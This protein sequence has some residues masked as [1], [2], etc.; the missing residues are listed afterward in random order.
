MVGGDVLGR[1]EDA[2]SPGRGRRRWPPR[3]PC[4]LTSANRSRTLSAVPVNCFTSFL[5]PGR[6]SSGRVMLPAATLSPDDGLSSRGRGDARR[7]ARRSPC[8]ARVTVTAPG[9]TPAASSS[10]RAQR[11]RSTVARARR[12][13][14][15]RREA[16]AQLVVDGE[17]AAARC[18][19]RRRRRR[20]GRGA[21]AP[22]PPYRRRRPACRASPRAPCAS[23]EPP[24]ARRAPTIDHRH[25]VGVAHGEAQAAAP[26]SAGASVSRDHVVWGRDPAPAHGSSPTSA[27]V[28]PWTWPGTTERLD[29]QPE[30]LGPAGAGSRRRWPARRR[31]DR[32]RFE[33]VVGRRRYA[34]F[35]CREGGAHAGALPGEP[36]EAV[37]LAPCE[38]KGASRSAHPPAEAP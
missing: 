3:R 10:C 1:D 16:R 30:R 20:G 22:R 4:S 15:P 29:R 32:P 11:Q 33:A 17:A 23:S 36:A 8:R 34:A 9:G 27:S 5:L 24:V 26:P 2:T 12:A 25:A 37:A 7:S 38:V 18:S 6:H 21:Q 14:E 31:R 19:G 28:V 13:R 35:P